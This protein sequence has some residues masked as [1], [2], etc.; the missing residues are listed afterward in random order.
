M[1]DGFGQLC[2]ACFA[3]IWTRRCRKLWL[4]WACRRR[5]APPRP[6]ALHG[7]QLR[8]RPPCGRRCSSCRRSWPQCGQLRN[9]RS[10][11]AEVH[12]Y[13]VRKAV[14]LKSVVDNIQAALGL[15]CAGL[16]NRGKII[17]LTVVSTRD[18]QVAHR[19]LY[20]TAVPDTQ[21]SAGAAAAHRCIA[22]SH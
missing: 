7:A 8:R 4:R 20:M 11:L 9:R 14:H 15:Q 19:S 3:Q 13:I 17:Q 10:S 5:R 1:L 18:A 2:L 16:Y 12:L 21:Y 22:A 6:T